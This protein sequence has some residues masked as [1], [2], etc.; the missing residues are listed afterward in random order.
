ME[1]MMDAITPVPLRQIDVHPA[2]QLRQQWDPQTDLTLPRLA[3]SLAGPEGL[4]HPI[5]VVP[6]RTST[7]FGRTYTLIAGHRRLVAARRLG[8]STIPARVLPPSDPDRP[9]ERLVLLAIALRENTERQDLTPADRR[10]ALLRL[11]ALYEEAYPDGHRPRLLEDG[12][13][14][15]FTRWAATVTHIPRRT[16]QRDLA[17]AALGGTWVVG[18]TLPAPPAP[19]ASVTTRLHYATTV[20][21][22]LVGALKDFAEALAP[23]E[24]ESQEHLAVLLPILHDLK[25]AVTTLQT[26]WAPL[27]RRHD[28]GAA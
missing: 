7:T 15:T 25:Q 9:Q 23:V 18:R 21:P 10:D 22:T 17:L 6:L 5:V 14:D 16:I 3:Q 27:T 8:W 24:P 28:A 26:T 12:D 13:I 2:F 1:D 4:L 11:R 19:T 20:G